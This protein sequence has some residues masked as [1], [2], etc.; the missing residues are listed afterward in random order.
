MFSLLF[1]AFFT[2]GTQ[3]PEGFDVNDAFNVN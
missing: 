1:S 2:Y 3:Y